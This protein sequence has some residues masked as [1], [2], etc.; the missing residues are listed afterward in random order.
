MSK[1]IIIISS[2]VVLLGIMSFFIFKEVTKIK[3]VKKTEDKYVAYVKINPSVKLDYSRKCT[4]YSNK[5]I[6]CEEP[7]VYEY[8]LVNEDA[9]E[10]FKDVNLLEGNNDLYSVIDNIVTKVSEKGI[11]VKDVEI[12]SD[13][14]EINTYL[15]TKQE[16]IKK[17]EETK[18]ENVNTSEIN[19]NNENINTGE[20]KENTNSENNTET[21]IET[22]KEEKPSFNINVNVQEEENIVNEITEEKEEEAKKKAEEEA[23][24]KAEEEAR[25]KAEEE[26]KKKAE[27]EAKKKAATTIYLKDKVTYDEVLYL[28]EC[29]KCFTTSLIN[30]LKRAKGHHVLSADD[31][32]ISVARITKLSGKYN[33][34]SYMGS[35]MLKKLTEAGATG[36]PRG[37]GSGE[38]L[39]KE[40]CKYFNLTCE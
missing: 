10:I 19:T 23:K 22:Q 20:I 24:K 40:Y 34:S 27:E 37:G 16:E 15:E 38:D 13:W 32:S 14:N 29:D 12:K 26:A 11:E 35:S 30:K 5:K 17:Q 39:T 28:Y 7:M 6:E 2:I 18:Q 33:S 9:K 3:I 31:S 21:N 36:D 4:E 1:K 8:E 25:I